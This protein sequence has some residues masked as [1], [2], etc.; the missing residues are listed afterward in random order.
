MGVE[1]LVG[2]DLRQPELRVP[3]YGSPRMQIYPSLTV[4]PRQACR[5][6]IGDSVIVHGEFCD[7]RGGGDSSQHGTVLSSR[8]GLGSASAHLA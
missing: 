7:S 8:G 2:F 4:L 1:A 6:W 5:I 3:A